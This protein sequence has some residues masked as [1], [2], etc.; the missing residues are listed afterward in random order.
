MCNCLSQLIMQSGYVYFKYF[1]S[2][3]FARQ[4][5]QTL[6][7]NCFDKASEL[8]SGSIAL[9]LIGT[10]NLNFPHDVAVQVMVDE[11]L[12]YSS[13]CP[14]SSIEEFRFIVHSEDQEG[15]SSFQDVFGNLKEENQR[16][17]PVP[18]RP[19]TGQANHRRK[20]ME[21]DQASG[22]TEG[23]D[24]GEGIAVALPFMS[25]Q[26]KVTVYGHQ[27]DIEEAIEALKNGVIKECHSTEVTDDVISRLP[28]YCKRDLRQKAREEDVGLDFSKHGAIILKGF[29][30]NV[31]TMHT[32]VSKVLQNQ[33]K[34]EHKMERAE[35]T[36]GNVQWCY[37]NVT[38][39]QEPFEKMANYDI[40]TAYQ[41]KTPSVSFMHKNMQAEIIFDLEKVKFLKTGAKKSVFRKEGKWLSY[42]AF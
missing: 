36:A 26:H 11:A 9:P 28:K 17:C 29:P 21:L 19:L 4:I 12:S 41:S 31:T 25:Y 18:G 37:L 15:I 7:W 3:C 2:F 6:L 33:L 24:D 23:E 34:E 10:G 30:I 13:K 27:Q 20:K 8:G 42:I 40:E 32:E 35:M 22:F 14:N 1:D 38:R 16:R 5:L 39:K